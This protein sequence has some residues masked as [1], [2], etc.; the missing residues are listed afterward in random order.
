MRKAD[1]ISSSVQ[2]SQGSGAFGELVPDEVGPAADRVL[3]L[4]NVLP[5][6]TFAFLTAPN[7]RDYMGIL[8]VL[9]WNTRWKSP[10]VLHDDL[11]AKVNTLIRQISYEPLRDAEF[12]SLLSKLH[13]WA[14]IG[15]QVGVAPSPKEWRVDWHQYWLKD[16][17]YQL[18]LALEEIHTRKQRKPT[19][20]KGRDYIRTVNDGLRHI[21]D[22]LHDAEQA[23]RGDVDRGESRRQAYSDLLELHDRDFG[24]FRTF[25]SDLN[26]DL[27][28]IGRA[29]N[30]DFDRLETLI[31]RL[32]AFVHETLHFFQARGEEIRRTAALLQ[33]ECLPGLIEGYAIERSAYEASTRAPPSDATHP[34][35]ATPLRGILTYFDWDGGLDRQARRIQSSAFL[36][37]QRLREYYQAFTLRSR[38][39]ELLDARIQEFVRLG[40]NAST[41]D[42]LAGW[43]LHL[44]PIFHVSFAPGIGSLANPGDPPRPGRKYAYHRTQVID[45]KVDQPVDTIIS[46][47]QRAEQIAEE[48]SNFI[49]TRILRGR[50]E[51]RFADLNLQDH[52]DF[53]ILLEAVRNDPLVAATGIAE[54]FRFTIH[55]PRASSTD[56]VDV[57][58]WIHAID[59]AY[60]AP[61]LIVRRKEPSKHVS[62][63]QEARSP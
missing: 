38:V 47:R 62:F 46:V 1:A 27:L 20:T 45:C 30:V 49:E 10:E 61:D 13:E 16:D 25:L 59:A 19:W 15:K 24:D 29:P 12:N 7:A 51:A 5:R 36:T 40:D 4:L 2:A 33:D 18:I 35:P 28:E 56:P 21:L 26:K 32:Q 43:T 14:L 9:Y 34:H 31:D 54:Y 53:R 41:D 3:A 60:Y 22:K 6:D 58:E 63:I 17:A 48:I 55:D 57:V 37:M 39:R 8:Y 11:H 52:Q 23:G 50:D 42:A 44:F